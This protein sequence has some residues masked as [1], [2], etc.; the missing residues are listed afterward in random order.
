MATVASVLA[1]HVS[2][3]VSCVD[4]I[5]CQGYIAGL[6]SEGM[7][8]RFLLDHGFVIP[9]PVGLK[10]VHDRLVA[11]IDR[12]ALDHDVPVVRFVRGQSKEDAA[13]PYLTAAAAADTEGIVMIG[14]AQERVSGWRGFR[15]GGSAS[16]P[17]FVY[18]RQSLW[19]NHYYFYVFDH[20]F[21]PGF[22]K[23]CPYAPYP[24]WIWCNGHEWLKRQLAQ[25]R[26]DFT[27][28][29]NGI[30]S[31]AD[32]RRAQRLADR[33]SAAK[34]RTFA[35]RWMA[36]LPSPLDGID[37]R[38]GR[39][40]EF[41]IR[42]LEVSD[43][44]VFDRPRAGRAFF[45]AAIREHLDVGR[46]EKV[47]L[48]VDRRIS[49]RTPGGFSTKVIT[50]GVDPQIQIHYRSS[51]VKAYFK[52]SRALRVETTINNAADFDVHKT[53]CEDN[54]RELVAVGKATNTRFLEALGEGS[55]P[56]P[57]AATLEQVVLPSM[58]EGVRAPGLRVGDPRVMALL[59]AISCFEHVLGGLTNASLTALVGALLDRPYSSRQ[60]SYDLRRLKRNGFI[61]R[62][63]H[64][65]V[66]QL[67][68]YGRATAT[69][70][71]KLVARAIVP[72]LTEF[73][74]SPGPPRQAR[75]P[76]VTAWRRYEH[77]LDAL[78][79]STGLA[80]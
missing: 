35:T 28:L 3:R 20:S 78:I 21:G 47:S 77:E 24:V 40:Y 26:I 11:G 49:K 14:V 72:T 18:R 2:F 31:A 63:P 27:E 53:L 54:W 43:T 61:D 74:T 39:R 41:S 22:I 30:R 50:P 4:R 29:D 80:A 6:Q 8:V 19:V 64:R 57:D 59:A 37:R 75:R 44:A 55:P 15:K 23:L 13:R 9:S 12:F 45:E 33:L 5:F 60:A 32:A 1:D 25:A 73:D 68:E 56:P 76:I 69:F 51:K 67:T 16:H 48:V 65:N 71:T 58:I 10:R 62:L 46:P 7:V 66:Y 52:A 36:G 38:A 17:H 42:Q 34:V 70:L 79:A